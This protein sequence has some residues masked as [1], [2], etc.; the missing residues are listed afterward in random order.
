MKQTRRALATVAAVMFVAHI[1]DV[2]WL[3]T[4]SFY[5]NGIH[6]SWLDCTALFGIGGVW[7]FVFFFKLQSKP[8]LPINDPRFAV[9]TL[10]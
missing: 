1:V 8:L 2:W 6:I 3:I 9:A 5:P 7:L 4:P 10:V